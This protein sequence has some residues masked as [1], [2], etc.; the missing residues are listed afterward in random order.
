MAI[1]IIKEKLGAILDDSLGKNL[2]ATGGIKHVGVN[3]EENVVVL[4]IAVGAL[5]PE[6]EKKL[7]REIAKI[8]K[9]DLKYSGLK[10]EIE[11]FKKLNSI[12]R[13][14]T[15]FIIIASGKGGVGKSTV[16]ANIAYALSKKGKKVG[17]IDA[18]IYGS[19]IPTLLDY[20]VK[21]AKIEVNSNKKIIPFMKNNI[22]F[23]STEFF[24]EVGTPILWRGAMVSSMIN[25][26]FYDVEWSKDLDYM[27][28]DMP[29]G[30]G[31]ATLDLKNIIPESD[32]IIVTTPHISASHVAI[33][34]GYAAQQLKHS[35]IGVIENMSYYLNKSNNEKEYIFGK[36]KG[37]ELAKK[38][39]VPLLAEIPINLPAKNT[40][41]YEDNEIIGQVYNNIAEIIINK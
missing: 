4:V 29:P 19:S 2:L 26:L 34:A 18:D 11:E 39:D 6:F 1:N 21:E 15:K 3:K 31:D 12:M 35:V 8:I 9:I 37:K 32:V 40:G 10:L 20:N 23:I 16:T 13:G 14:D 7:R 36:G 17:I 33:K 24:A 27:I 41:L 38:L 5:E 30:T 28:I 25:S 22:Q